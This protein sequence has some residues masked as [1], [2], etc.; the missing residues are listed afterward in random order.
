[1][2]I[3]LKKSLKKVFD[4][5]QKNSFKI[6]LKR[7]IIKIKIQFII[8]NKNLTNKLKN[9]MIKKRL[10]IFYRKLFLIMKKKFQ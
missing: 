1:M 3:R 8:N 9:N 5:I 10:M 4:Q 2:I 6:Y 7:K